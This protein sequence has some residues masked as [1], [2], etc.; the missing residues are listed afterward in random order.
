MIDLV[1][2]ISSLV[3]GITASVIAVL[4]WDDIVEWFRNRHQLKEADR[5]RI[6]FTLSQ[7]YANGEFNLVQG[8][9]DKRESVLV[10]GRKIRAKELD[11]RLAEHHAGRDLVIYE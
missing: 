5:D 2:L 11:P 8:I 10:S 6:A 4:Y 7:K 1:I 9:F 3:V